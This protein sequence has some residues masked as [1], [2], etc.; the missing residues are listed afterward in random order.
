MVSDYCFFEKLSQIVSQKKK[1]YR[2]NLSPQNKF[3]MKKTVRVRSHCTS[4]KIKFKNI[5]NLKK[6]IKKKQKKTRRTEQAHSN[7]HSATSEMETRK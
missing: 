5:N 3:A 4:V 1:F 7:S 2:P 6:I